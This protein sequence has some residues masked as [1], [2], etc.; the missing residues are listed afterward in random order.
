MQELGWTPYRLAY[1]LGMTKPAIYRL[2]KRNGRVS[3][4]SAE[5]LDR[6]CSVTGK[7]TDDPIEWMPGKRAKPR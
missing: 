5:S 4:L 7:K 2:L 6:L 3:R 1:E